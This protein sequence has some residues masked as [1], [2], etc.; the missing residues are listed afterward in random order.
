MSQTIALGGIDKQP[1]NPV[2]GD[3]MS[4]GLS[5]LYAKNFNLLIGERTA[6]QN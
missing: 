4:E 6:E 2:A 5:I 3:S 1:F